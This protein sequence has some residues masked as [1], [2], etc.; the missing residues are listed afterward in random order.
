MEIRISKTKEDL[1]SAFSI[2][3]KSLVQSD[4]VTH[5]AL[6]GGNSPRKIFDHLAEN[7]GEEID[8]TKV[9]IYWVDERCVHPLNE[10]SNFKMTRDH[11]LSKI[12]IPEENIHRMRGE[13]NPHEEAKR[14]GELLD[15]LLPA[16][17]GV[18]EFDLIVLGLGDDGHTASIFPDSMELW[19]SEENCAVAAHPTSGQKRVTLTGKVINTAQAVAF[20]VTGE[21]KAKIVRE[22]TRHQGDYK[23]YPASLVN[24]D[25]PDFIWFLDEEAASEL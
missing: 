6:S 1:A 11:L 10:E 21:N 18:P 4:K 3:F 19:D 24:P 23:K 20:L 16:E 22:I 12:N 8:W 5:V 14:Y 15:K 13:D 17:N 2:F 9:N 25:T 7:H